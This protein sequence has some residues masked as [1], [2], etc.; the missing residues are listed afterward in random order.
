MTDHQFDGALC[1]TQ[2]KC[3]GMTSVLSLMEHGYPSRTPFR[4]LHSSYEP[5][6]PAELRKLAPRTFCEAMLHSLQ[7]K[8]DDFRFGV[9]RV[10]FRPG[11][12][13]QFDRIMRS[14]PESL[15]AIVENVKKYLVKSRW[16]KSQFCALSVIKR[17]LRFGN[18]RYLPI[19]F[20]F[21]FSAK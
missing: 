2:L 5:L 14:D 15:K 18:C 13:A 11:K 9:S 21:F 1:W 19:N 4:E 12:F 8:D 7:L 6:L 10:F 3:S 16:I 20:F 17:K